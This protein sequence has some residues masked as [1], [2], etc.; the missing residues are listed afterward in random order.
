MKEYYILLTVRFGAAVA[1]AVILGS[2]SVVAFNHMPAVWFR[3]DGKLPEDID[4]RQRITSSPWKFVFTGVFGVC[5]LYMAVRDTLQYELAVIF[6]LFIVLE[7][8]ISDWK[9]MVV[10][11]Q[12]SFLLAVSAVG[13]TG[14][15]KQWWDPLA[16]AAAGG[17]LGLGI[18]LLGHLIYKKDAIGGADIKFLGAMG[19]VTGPQGILWVFV[20]TTLVT[21]VHGLWLVAF[22]KVSLKEHKPMMPYAFVG[23]AI[24]LV[25]LWDILE[26][27]PI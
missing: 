24:Y 22:R 23:S 6:V 15:N 21:A 25:I 4:Q 18:L 16:G 3:D 20:L 8:A 12:L 2:G 27:F 10:P 11:D 19:M 17:A 13:F 14:M 1:L 26:E 5:G 9:Y 7:M